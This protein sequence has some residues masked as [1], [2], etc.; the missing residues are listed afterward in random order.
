MEMMVV[1]ARK[2][3]KK[4]NNGEDDDNDGVTLKD[5]LD[6]MMTLMLQGS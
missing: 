3:K 1:E 2:I 5:D 4:I 6:E